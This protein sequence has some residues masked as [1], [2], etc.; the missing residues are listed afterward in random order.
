[1]KGLIMRNILITKILLILFI[2][3]TNIH[4]QTEYEDHIYGYITDIKTGKG[5]PGVWVEVINE[6]ITGERVE[7]SSDT[8]GRYI[9]PLK[10]IKKD[11][12]SGSHIIS[13]YHLGQNYPNPF[14]PG[15]HIPFQILKQG[16][17]TI[18]IFNILGQRI[19][20]LVNRM[21]LPGTYAVDWDGTNQHGRGVGAGVYFYR[22][23]GNEFIDSKK[24]ILLDGLSGSPQPVGDIFPAEQG[25]MI[26]HDPVV[27]IRCTSP[28]TPIME[29]K[30]IS[31][32]SANFR[33]DIQLEYTDKSLINP[34]AVIVSEPTEDQRVFVSGLP[35]AIL[36]KITGV[37]KVIIKNKR[38]NYTVD[39]RVSY[40]AGFI[41]ME[42]PAMAGDELEINLTFDGK[43]FGLP[44]T[45]T[46][47]KF[48][49]PVVT[50]TKPTNG[51]K[52][53]IIKRNMF[54]RFSAQIDINT[55]SP[56]T[57]FLTDNQGSNLPGSYSFLHDDI[58]VCFDPT[59]NLQPDSE[60]T[61]T[62]KSGIK[63]KHGL[64]LHSDVIINFTTAIE[65]RL[66]PIVFSQAKGAF[67]GSIFIIESDG[68]NCQQLTNFNN[69]VSDISPCYS[70]DASKIAFVRKVPPGDWPRDY[71]TRDIMI[72]NWDG[73]FL[74][75][76]TNTPNG[77]ESDPSFSP[78]GTQIAY[79][80][81]WYIYMMDING[82]NQYKVPNTGGP[83]VKASRAPCWSPDGKKLAYIISW[84]NVSGV[85][86]WDICTIDIDGENRINLTE[87]LT[88]ECAGPAWSPDGQQIAFSS[89]PAIGVI[90]K[91]MI[92]DHDGSNLV[93]LADDNIHWYPQE[94]AVSWSPDG[95][96]IVYTSEDYTTEYPDFGL[97]TINPD[98]TEKQRIHL[99]NAFV[100]TVDWAPIRY[101]F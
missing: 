57:I 55:I 75:N 50:E 72:M 6:A 69:E 52:D 63:D 99:N 43:T 42:L 61:L 84:A 58:V 33:Y 28:F 101:G 23:R 83:L 8:T 13:K 88:G 25:V 64:A 4:A 11:L 95:K 38:T 66:P 100:L 1:M 92:M 24:M 48:R 3:L 94:K 15:T 62:I 78:D 93:T 97:I 71:E 14:N 12:S 18:E 30:N 41:L 32:S 10:D 87:E 26:L 17:V 7:V 54:V 9:I 22:L 35:G 40:D 76:L 56:A 46:V 85:H 27:K 89:Y 2:C 44:G 37:E 20:T 82:L 90:Y 77:S 21:M 51:E 73:S 74:E 98:G 59:D 96:K 70:P 67:V 80:D 81:G 53:I 34:D 47:S 19:K 86:E 36:N 68:Q 29:Q 65:P 16:M 5:I 79:S 31:I 39:Q 45:I 49:P 60:Y 91:L